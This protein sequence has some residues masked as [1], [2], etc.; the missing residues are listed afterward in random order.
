MKFDLKNTLCFGVAGNFAN[1]LEQ[2]RENS[3][4]VDVKTTTADEP[5]G[6]FPYYIPGADTYHGTCPHSSDTIDYPRAL[7]EQ[8]NLQ[9]EAEACVLFEVVYRNQKVVDLL[10]KAFAAFND[11]SIR[12][13]GAKKISEKKNW[14]ANSKGVSANFLP[15][16]RFEKGG[17]MDT[18]HIASFL[19]RNDSLHSYGNDS[20]VLTYSY[21]Y[22]QLKEWMI[23]KFNTQE[24]F[25]PLE[26]LPSVFKQTDYPEQ[27][28]V[29]L[30]A[31]SYTDFGE[32][33]FLEPGDEVS[34]YLYDA[35]QNALEQVYEHA[36]G[37]DV[38][39]K[40]SSILTQMVV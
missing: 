29:A 4:F 5:K 15:L 37:H 16:T 19:K 35:S 20:A 33:V 6:L 23:D 32:H 14:S 3:D 7:F 17:E 10:P 30:G 9:L 39:L 11:C 12:K 38:E 2:A 31:T 21:F 28:L 18:F 24:D 26:D 25:G 27:I 34:V 8:A 36:L 40:N 1:H 13:A 22:G